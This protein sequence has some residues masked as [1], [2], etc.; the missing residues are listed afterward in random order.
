VFIF[1]CFHFF[2][3]FFFCF[4]LC[5][6]VCFF[7]F[8]VLSFPA[9]CWFLCFFFF[10]GA[11]RFFF[12]WFCL[13]VLVFFFFLYPSL[14]PRGGSFSARPTTRGSPTLSRIPDSARFIAPTRRSSCPVLYF[15]C[16][17]DQDHSLSLLSQ[18]YY[19]K[20]GALFDVYREG[21]LAPSR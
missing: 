1:V 14:I 7:L 21:A 20:P 19:C 4:L 11:F 10:F 13:V 2:C 3:V 17:R 18:R 9:L 5:L 12:S 16:G 6:L 15:L 8:F